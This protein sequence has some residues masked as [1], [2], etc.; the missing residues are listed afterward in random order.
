M[1]KGSTM[2]NFSLLAL[3][4]L[5]CGQASADG[6]TAS[7]PDFSGDAPLARTTTQQAAVFAGGCFWGV[8][9]VF[10]HV[11]GVVSATSGYSGGT[12]A[13][14]TYEAVS[15]GT[16]GH[17][18]AVKVVYDPARITYGQL[19]KIYFAVA[20]NPTELDR[21]GPDTGPQYRSGIFAVTA[22]QQR[23]A[24]SYIG[25]LDAAHVYPRKIVTTVTALSAFYPAEDYH[26]NYA[27][28]HPYDPYIVINDRPKVERLKQQFPELYK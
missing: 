26:Q 2:R 4:A 27:A 22:E 11:K 13:T 21:Q 17:A 15:N 23:S 24:A 16:T 25:Q 8:Q 20:H 7:L 3:S 1:M 28:R 10:Q 18:E 12:A 6:Q 14:A 9:A 19:L 5:L